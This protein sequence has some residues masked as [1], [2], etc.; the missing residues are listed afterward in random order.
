VTGSP[1]DRAPKNKPVQGMWQPERTQVAHFEVCGQPLTFRSN[2]QRILEIAAA[3]FEAAIPEPDDLPLAIELYATEGIDTQFA[4][5]SLAAP[6]P[7][8]HNRRHL[9][10][11][12]IDRTSH[13]VVDL[14]GG[15]GFG[16][17]GQDLIAQPEYARTL[18]IEAMALSMLGPA[19]GLLPLHASCVVI[20]GKA[21]LLCGQSGAG[22]STLA[23]ACVHRGAQFLADDV[24]FLRCWGEGVRVY[25]L[26]TRARVMPETVALFPEL[27]HAAINVYLNGSWKQAID[28]DAVY[29]G[30]ARTNAS[31]GAVVLLAPPR[32][33]EPELRPLPEGQALDRLAVTWQYDLPPPHEADLCLQ[34][35]LSQGVFELGVADDPEHSARL[36]VDL[37]R[38]HREPS[39]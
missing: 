30:M 6:A 31:L 3:S 36:L 11:I 1:D 14:L 20:E 23:L 26:P 12:V 21:L 18:L 5:G 7:A 33:G 10:S 38:G 15:F 24:V 13:A 28:M 2:D 19:R 27:G 25:G 39:A 16:V 32:L 9:F 37:L 35:A 17:V 34:R 8:H 29:P 4:R 22:K